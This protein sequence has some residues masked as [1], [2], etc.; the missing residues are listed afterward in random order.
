MKRPASDKKKSRG[1]PSRVVGV[2]L[3][4]DMIASVDE[5]RRKESDIPGRGEA[6]RRL[7]DRGLTVRQNLSAA[8]SK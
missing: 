6:I 4:A 8:T 7:L 3:Y 2:R 1:L 5:W